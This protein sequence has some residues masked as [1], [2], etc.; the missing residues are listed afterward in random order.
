MSHQVG[1]FI[2]IPVDLVQA[3]PIAV[4][5]GQEMKTRTVLGKPGHPLLKMTDSMRGI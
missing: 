1:P 5:L 3:S 2:E 4:T